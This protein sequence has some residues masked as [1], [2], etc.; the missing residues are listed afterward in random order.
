ML[1]HTGLLPER[2]FPDSFASEDHAHA[3]RHFPLDSE[4]CKVLT[5]SLYGLLCSSTILKSPEEESGMRVQLSNPKVTS[6]DR[7]CGECTGIFHGRSAQVVAAQCSFWSWYWWE[8][9]VSFLSFFF[10][11]FPFFF[12]FFFSFFSFFC[13]N[14]ES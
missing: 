5:S 12:F 9:K 7:Q 13:A 10:F 1:I 2:V 8:G 4:V 6:A 3:Q 14:E 11:L